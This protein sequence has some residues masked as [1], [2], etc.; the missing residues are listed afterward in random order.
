[1]ERLIG[2]EWQ[3]HLTE[4]FVQEDQRRYTINYGSVAGL[5]IRSRVLMESGECVRFHQ[6]FS[7]PILRRYGNNIDELVG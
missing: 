6:W 1:M 7:N 3:R 4:R 2:V 5:V